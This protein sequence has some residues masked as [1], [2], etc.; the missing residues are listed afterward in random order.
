MHKR[1]KDN[2]D[3]AKRLSKIRSKTVEPVLGTLNHF[4]SMRRVK[5]RGMLGAHKHC[6]SR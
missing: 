6:L 3:Y 1:L 5:T 4:T 2:L